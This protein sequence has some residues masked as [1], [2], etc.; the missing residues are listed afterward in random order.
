MEQ[1]LLI[2]VSGHVLI[3]SDMRTC[4]FSCFKKRVTP[5]QLTDI[6]YLLSLDTIWVKNDLL[7]M[8]NFHYWNVSPTIVR[9]KNMQTTFES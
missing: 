7:F 2:L 4:G 3:R 8:K 5:G 1:K 9:D 6:F